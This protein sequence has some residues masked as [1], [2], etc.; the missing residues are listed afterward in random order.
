MN[1]THGF[2]LICPVGCV[3]LAILAFHHLGLALSYRKHAVADAMSS[4]PKIG[5][6]TALEAT[7]FSMLLNSTVAYAVGAQCVSAL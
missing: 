3:L 7:T 2:G 1:A 6:G 4:R 5:L